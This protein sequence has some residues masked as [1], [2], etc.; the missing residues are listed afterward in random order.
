M[1]ATGGPNTT[2]FF[3]ALAIAATICSS[4]T[5]AA[6]LHGDQPE[7]Q[8]SES[9]EEA[10]PKRE[11]L[12]F[13]EVPIVISAAKREQ[14]I[15]ESPSSIS[16]IT[17]E[18]IR[19][20]GATNIADILRRVPGL[21]VLRITPSDAQISARGFNESN[22]NDILLLIDGR[23]AYVDFFGIV[24]WDDL[25]IVLEEIDR[26]EIIRGPGSALYGANAFSGVINIITKTPE[27]A[28]GTTLSATGGEFDT[29]IW[30]FMH[31][32]VINQW[33]YKVV[34][35]WDEANSFDDRDDNDHEM[36]K[37]NALIK[38]EFDPESRIYFSTGVNEGDGN[39]L[40][41][42]SRF[43]R[44]GTFG[45]A[46]LNYD[47]E[48]W[49]FQAFYNLVDIDVV[50]P[51]NEE[52]SIINN[53]FDVEMQNTFE[54]WEK[55]TVTWGANYR[56]NRVTSHE[57]IGDDEQEDLFSI[58][59][60]DQYRMLEDMTL[61]AGFRVDSHPLTGVHF[62]PRASLVY[63][64]WPDHVFRAS[65]ARAFRNPSFV[66]SFLDLNIGGAVM[67]SGNRDLNAEEIT[68]F[69]LGY[70]TRF[71][72]NKLQFKVDTFYNIV[73]EIIEF[74]NVN[75]LPPISPFPPFVFDYENEGRAVAYGGEISLEYHVSD[76]L[77]GYLNYSYQELKAKSD[78]VQFQ[79]NE[80]GDVIESSPRHKINAGVYA[81]MENG[82]NGS[83][84]LNFVDDVEFGF[85]DPA[86]TVPTE[87]EL[88]D[89]TRVDV[90]IGYKC[91]KRDVEAS[92]IFQN[93]LDDSHREF[94]TGERFQ[95]LVLFQVKARF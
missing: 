94:P 74:R 79:L 65:V 53:V 4:L 19:R 14:P 62:S 33:S 92:L 41:R 58:F 18:D 39:T 21:D 91:P 31:A 59:V 71:L 50:A 13:E 45:Y 46:K 7:A 88:D 93:A 35:S 89:Y 52:R 95:R 6:T 85:F 11:L 80:K 68:S 57:I 64:P 27:E 78:G 81:E 24:V 60:Q 25:P 47:Y 15:T 49:K 67:A 17:A 82:L 73:D 56:H 72:E 84:D 70:Q 34:A 8:T 3:L 29:Y 28:K 76:R 75:F 61:T 77:S 37:G 22:N 48:N 38:Y 20:A 12:L 66:E 10:Y 86:T 55:H 43:D 16:I 26:I 23:S 51:D 87:V 83:V 9:T 5:Y 30:T 40:T 2:V 63:Q 32:D 69:E 1:R 90:R 42:V 54:P 44:E 36:F